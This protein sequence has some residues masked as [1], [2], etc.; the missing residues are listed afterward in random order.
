[1]LWVD[2][3]RLGRETRYGLV[4]RCLQIEIDDSTNQKLVHFDRNYFK[5]NLAYNEC[6]D[7]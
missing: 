5:T 6:T 7:Q 1:M 2:I 3:G 4:L